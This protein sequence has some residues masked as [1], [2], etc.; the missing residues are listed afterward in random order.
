MTSLCAAGLVAIAAAQAPVPSL[1]SDLVADAGAEFRKGN[2]REAIKKIE[3]ARRENLLK[4]TSDIAKAALTEGLSHFYLGETEPAATAFAQVLLTNPDYDLDP[5]IYGEEAKKALDRVRAQPELQEPLRQRREEIKEAAAR[6]AEVR[7]LAEEAER[8]RKELASLPEQL[9]SLERHSPLLNVLP[10]GIPQIE[11]DRVTSGV[12]LAIAQGV[13]LTATVLTYTQVQSFIESDGK[14]SSDNLTKAKDW[15]VANWVSVAAAAAV[16]V[17]GVVDAFVHYNE[18]TLTLIPRDDYLKLK[19]QQPA[20]PAQAPASTPAP[21]P[22]AAPPKPTATF[23]L[24]P[25][26]GGAAVG[27]AGTF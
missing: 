20:T 5:L 17:A 10:F 4:E 2:F 1:N 23:F 21:A 26:A 11:Q 22:P 16:Y 3:Q 14:V 9:P 18:R 7:R 24:A 6:E 15:R 8:K 13:S 25:T 12:L 19:S 27:I